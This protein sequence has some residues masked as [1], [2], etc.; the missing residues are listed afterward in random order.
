MKTVTKILFVLAVFLLPAS[1]LVAQNKTLDNSFVI[2]N[3]QLPEKADFY[4]T[5]ILAADMEQYRLREKRVRLEFE[6]GFELELYSAKELFVQGAQININ[7]YQLNHGN[8]QVP[9]FTV[10]PNGYLAAKV[11]NETKK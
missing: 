1:A 11:F 6:N 9:V 3:N 10:L 8:G 5:C 7:N 2:I 4:K